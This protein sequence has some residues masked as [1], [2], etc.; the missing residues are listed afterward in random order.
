MMKTVY[1]SRKLQQCFPNVYAG[2]SDALSA[3]GMA[4]KFG[5][6]DDN[7]WCRDYCPVPT[8]GGLKKFAYKLP[9]IKLWFDPRIDCQVFPHIV[10]DGG[11]VVQ[12]GKRVIVT[13]IVFHQNIGS[14]D[15]ITSM[16]EELFEK[17]IV[18]IP[19]E[20]GDDLG[21]ADGI[22]H[23]CGD[24]RVLVNDYSIISRH[25]RKYQHQVDGVLHDAGLEV[26]PIP[27]AYHR[28]PDMTEKAFR[29]KY[30][31]ADSFNP[32]PG[33]YLNFLRVENVI[34]LPQFGFPEDSQAAAIIKAVFPQHKIYPIECY[35]LSMLGGVL[36]C[37]T[38]TREI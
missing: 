12:D 21:H 22:V 17:P 28:C 37:V 27:N 30:P 38:W 26:V 20:P 5:G 32:A 11:N 10:L 4:V 13:E 25:W 19:V 34:L 1:V 29:S 36:H 24:G 35:D 15:Q 23:L 31:M 14:R 18:F 33:Y 8:E 3:N 16:L 2:I 7:I 6:D 9:P